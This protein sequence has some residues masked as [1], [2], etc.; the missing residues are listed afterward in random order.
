VSER[1]RT[2]AEQF[3]QANEQFV[4]VVE[5]LPDERWREQCHDEA[6][7]VCAVARHIAE[8]YQIELDAFRVIAAGEPLKPVP[9]AELHEANARRAARD[10]TCTRAEVLA[11]ARRNAAE[12]AA[13][14]RGLSDEQLA[15]SG[16]YVDVLRT[17]TLDQLVER[18]LIGHIRGHL[19]S[20]AAANAG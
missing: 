10:A 3:E 4:A 9:L 1:A 2:L 13:F 18:I 11:L 6:R 12:A 20:I 16:V 7:P 19:R 14:V 17:M 15:R 8:A 5:A